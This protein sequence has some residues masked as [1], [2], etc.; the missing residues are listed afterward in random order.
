MIPTLYLAGTRTAR[1]ALLVFVPMVAIGLLM[2]APTK[3]ISER[4]VLV[5]VHW[6]IGLPLMLGW[7]LN[8]LI[9]EALHRP[10]AMTMPGAAQKILRGHT[11]ITAAV[12]VAF[13]VAAKIVL[14]DFPLAPLVAL[15]AAALA[16]SLPYEEGRVGWISRIPTVLYVGLALFGPRVNLP[17]IRWIEAA[18]VLWTLAASAVTVA[19]FV[20]VWSKERRRVRAVT[21]YTSSFNA[22]FS[23]PLTRQRAAQTQARQKTSHR[24]WIA[25]GRT[26]SA[27][28]WLKALRFERGN[29]WVGASPLG[30]FG[31]GMLVCF[32]ALWLPAFLSTGPGTVPAKM[33][34]AFRHQIPGTT[35]M[36]AMFLLVQP[37]QMAV[38]RGGF[39]YPLSRARRLAI[40]CY[41][42]VVQLGAGCLMVGCGTLAVGAVAAVSEGTSFPWS[43][44]FGL[45]A[46]ASTMLIFTPLVL[47]ARLQQ[48]ASDSRL[49]LVLMLIGGMILGPITW[50]WVWGDSD[51]WPAG[52][53]PLDRLAVCVALIGLSLL[54]GYLAVRRFFLTADL[55]QK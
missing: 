28:W 45:M 13:G 18:P 21:P 33:L 47:W 32:G 14:P 30:A 41:G 10:F 11:I 48:E 54:A 19:S 38:P 31:V 23:G 17:F 40:T 27:R 42:A 55:I 15:A 26:D 37:L 43:G 24:I 4:D 1:I 12:A 51:N 36:L 20:A 53:V 49:P 8:S 3:V 6:V 50:H 39:L 5:V 7:I 35:N 2:R 44:Y 9:H 52:A 25:E 34:T 29:E 22:V 46:T 16:S